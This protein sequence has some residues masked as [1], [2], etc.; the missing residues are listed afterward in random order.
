MATVIA[1]TPPGTGVIQPAI[2]AASSKATSPQ[3][4]P[5][6]RRWIPTSMTAAPGLI[7]SAR[8][9]SGRPTAA[10]RMSAS[11]AIDRGVLR[12]GVADGDGRVAAGPFLHQ[13]ERH[14]LAD[15]VRPPQHDRSGPLGLDPA[16]LEQLLHAQRGAG[17]EPG[18]ADGQQAGVLG[19][20]AVDVLARVDPLDD[21]SF[22]DVVRQRQLHEEAVDG[23]IGVEGLDGVEQ[24][25]LGH[26]G[27]QSADLAAHAGLAAGVLLAADVDLAGRILAD[28][29]DRQP[30]H[31]P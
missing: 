18:P 23:R 9:C 17:D 24:I 31:D 3:S 30:R 19:V 11:R 16:V 6:S 10:I 26:V 4:V 15:D 27:R 29:D 22:V 13:Q 8:T 7:Q 21:P 14:R 1:P 28:Q 5:S 12:G 20:E 25:G 2:S